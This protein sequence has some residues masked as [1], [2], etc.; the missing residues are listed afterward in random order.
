MNKLCLG[1]PFYHTYL[2]G[3]YV[4]NVV[5]VVSV[6]SVRPCVCICVC[7]PIDAHAGVRA[8]LGV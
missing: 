7:E 6:V 8:G 2:C 1:L 3:W 4:V 5:V